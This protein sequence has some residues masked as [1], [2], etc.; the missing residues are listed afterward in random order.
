MGIIKTFSDRLPAM[1]DKLF[2]SQKQG[3]LSD[4]RESYAR[5]VWPASRYPTLYK[6]IPDDIH[7][8]VVWDGR[9]L[10]GHEVPW[11]AW[12]HLTPA[13]VST[14]AASSGRAAL[15][16]AL[17]VSVGVVAWTVFQR[18]LPMG[19]REY[20]MWAEQ[21][22]QTGPVIGWHVLRALDLIYGLG[23]FLLGAAL[24]GALAFV[25]TWFFAFWRSLKQWWNEASEPLRTPTR[26]ALL[27]WKAK[28]DIRPAEY[29]AYCR[30][31]EDA[32]GRL[33]DSPIIPVG[34]AEGVLRARGDMES[35]S[36]GQT[37]A[38]DGESIRQHTLVLGG[39]GTGKTR[40]V[41]R[42][43]FNSIMSADWGRGHKIGAYVTDG[44]G[45]LWRD[46]LP[47]VEGRE[48]VR[49]IGTGAGH[50]GVNLLQGMTPLEVATVFKSVTGQVAGRA[51]ADFWPE[52]A[53]VLLMH[54]AAV[55]RIIQTD[56]EPAPQWETLS[57]YSLL[58]LAKIATDE[59]VLT[60]TCDR[61]FA[62]AEAAAENGEVI[63]PEL[64]EALNSALWLTGTWL[65]MASETR[66]SIIA[67]VNV[68]LGKLGGAGPLA[69]AFFTGQAGNTIDVDHALNGGVVMCA[70]GETE[71]G[72]AGKVVNCWLKAR[73]FIAARRRLV[74][75][76]AACATHSCAL[77]A[78]EFQ[79]LV[80]SGPDSDTTFWNV[81]RETGVF[82]V[83]ATQSIAALHQVL[84]H[85][86]TSNLVNLLR[87]KI[88]LKTEEL[89]TID[90]VRKLAGDLPRG[91]E[92][93][94][95]FFSTQGA[96]ELSV[97]DRPAGL[98]KASIRQFLPTMPVLPTHAMKQVFSFNPMNII[99]GVKD[100]GAQAASTSLAER[101]R[102]EDKNERVVVD[103]LSWRPKIESDELLLGS[104]YAFAIIQ[105]AGGDRADIIDLG[106]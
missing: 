7:R 98:P 21:I 10:G 82:L 79:M 72:M 14:A 47:S 85:E 58:G 64:D 51:D 96:R 38:F 46:L 43:L 69:T 59:T 81:A 62:I 36:Q 83:A 90:F 37:V 49:V 35:P 71:W 16:V 102:V 65:P 99:R 87:S 32:T 18:G 106:A 19:Y 105:R 40:R 86:Q 97:P 41:M 6:D 31:V 39:T 29:R 54:S 30:Q 24:A 75:D 101:L 56:E 53:S 28:A 45:T 2:A 25:S 92:V 70:V 66:S 4:N 63:A 33:S 78:D 22:G 48:D 44:K 100:S 15:K 76:P 95:A 52:Q 17:L 9:L 57:P 34:T 3:P 73:L 26:D 77:I 89:S 103:G 50:Y 12:K 61:I 80:T 5:Q 42:P 23:T 94:P 88:V 84:G 8:P 13:V 27:I 1:I 67:N 60:Q 55:A 11:L 104:G 20:P 93:N 91:W 68:V 74:S